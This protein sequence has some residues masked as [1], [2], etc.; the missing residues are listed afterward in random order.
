MTGNFHT[1]TRFSDG[2]GEPEEFV[3]HA[4]TLGFKGI[5]FSEHAPVNF[6]NPW[7]LKWEDAGA[8]LRTINRLKQTYQNKIRVYTS[9]EIDY[10]PGVSFPFDMFRDGYQLDYTIGS[11]HLVKNPIN[12]RLWFIDGGDKNDYAKGLEEAFENDID[13]GVSQYYHQQIEMIKNQNPDILGHCDK[14]KMHNQGVY[15]DEHSHA[16]RTLQG[17]L[18][19]ELRRQ[20][21]I[22]EVNTRGIYKGRCAE[23]YPGEHF[24]ALCIK[25]GIPLMLNSDAH[26]AH[27]LDGEFRETL[28][29]LSAVGVVWLMVFREGRFRRKH[30]KEILARL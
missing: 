6:D 7:S 8:Y 1:H 11:V 15:F 12:G 16:V 22:V 14:I 26:A 23:L 9:L 25:E 5:G 4:M 27:E 20:G 24:I 3:Q 17:S 21:T 30:T 2:K 19:A 10:I 28:R 29:W 18:I 13:F